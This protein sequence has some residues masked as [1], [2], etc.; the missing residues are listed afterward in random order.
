MDWGAWRATV[1]SVSKSRTWL[2]QLS[3]QAH[4]EGLVYHLVIQDW[5]S[6]LSLI[7]WKPDLLL[8]AG[9]DLYWLT[10]IHCSFL[11]NYAARGCYIG[12]LKT[13]MLGIFILLQFRHWQTKKKKQTF[14]LRSQFNIYQ[15]MT[16]LGTSHQLIPS[17]QN[18]ICILSYLEKEMAIHS[19]I[20]AWKIPCRRNMVG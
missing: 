14:T 6:D 7:F 18:G 19:N 4:I 8:W 15:N 10:E 1:H 2:K 11:R 3:R 16:C 9:A 20:L 12:S 17:S 5:Y 13:A